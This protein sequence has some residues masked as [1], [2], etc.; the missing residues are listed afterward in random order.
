MQGGPD[1][2]TLGWI[3]NA[4]AAD[5]F[6]TGEPKQQRCAR[7]VGTV[8]DEN[9]APSVASKQQ[10]RTVARVAKGIAGSGFDEQRRRGYAPCQSH[11]AHDFG[12][13]L[14]AAAAARQQ[15]H[16]CGTFPKSSIASSS[17]HRSRDRDLQPSTTIA[18][19]LVPRDIVG[20]LGR[21]NLSSSIT[22]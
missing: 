4:E 21:S 10:R 3:S 20:L 13:G 2:G 17:R 8:T 7:Q 6:E 18:C 5:D 14:D 11:P 22:Q 15:Q 1:R 19:A 12:L 16:Q 9:D